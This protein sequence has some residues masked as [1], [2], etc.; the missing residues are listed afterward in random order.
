MDVMMG[1]RAKAAESGDA[2]AGDSRALKRLEFEMAL[3]IGDTVNRS[4]TEAV[5]KAAEAAGGDLVFVLPALG[6]NGG[7]VEQAVVRLVEDGSTQFVQVR[8]SD[9]GFVVSAEAEIDA[10]FLGFARASIDVLERLRED[11]SVLAPLAAAAH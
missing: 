4:L 1:A 7:P 8:G 9:G 10:G 5:R 6:P 3:E 11:R 2:K